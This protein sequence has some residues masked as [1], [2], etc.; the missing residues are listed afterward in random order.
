MFLL[1]SKNKSSCHYCHKSIEIVL[2]ATLSRAWPGELG[3]YI[4]IVS[5]HLSNSHAM[6]GLVLYMSTTLSL[7]GRGRYCHKC[8]VPCYIK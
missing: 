1:S 2:P 7:L 4:D 6:H 8:V 5:D 3:R